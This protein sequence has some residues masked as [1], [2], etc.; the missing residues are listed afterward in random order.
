MP[1]PKS[2]IERRVVKVVLPL[3]LATRFELSKASPTD[4]SLPFALWQ[5]FFT[6]ALREHFELQTLDIGALAGLPQSLPVRG[7]PATISLLRTLLERKA[8][9]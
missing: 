4:G 5:E 6:R 7:H 8:P 2:P 9:Q 1:R 3:D